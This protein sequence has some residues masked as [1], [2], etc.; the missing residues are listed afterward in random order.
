MGPL[1]NC[2]SYGIILTTHKS[3]ILF[4]VDPSRNPHRISI[5]WNTLNEIDMS[6]LI[7]PNGRV[8]TGLGFDHRIIHRVGLKVVSQ[9]F[10]FRTG[11]LKGNNLRQ[12]ANST[13]M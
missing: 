3:T 1:T 6:E 4:T 12:Y 11:K 13:T 9:E 5:S 10:D 7:V 2:M 8:I